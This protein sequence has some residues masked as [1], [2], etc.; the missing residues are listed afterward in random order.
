MGLNITMGLNCISMCKNVYAYVLNILI[1]IIIDVAI[2]SLDLL[3]YY[4]INHTLY[5]SIISLDL[6]ITSAAAAKHQ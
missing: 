4:F 6:Y 2:L 1:I 3:I 5:V